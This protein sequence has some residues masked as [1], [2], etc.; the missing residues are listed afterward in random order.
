MNKFMLL[1][2]SVQTASARINTPK[3]SFHGQTHK[4]FL[5]LSFDS[6]FILGLDGRFQQVNSVAQETLGFTIEEFLEKS[7]Q[8]LIHP[9]D[10]PLMSRQWE[11]LTTTNQN[12]SFETRCCCQDGSYK[13]LLWN[14]TLDSEEELIYAIARDITQIKEAD[15]ARKHTEALFGL[16]V[17]SVKDYA[18]YMLDPQGRVMS[19]NQGAERT[20]GF[21][22]S[23][24][25]G[26]HVS[27]FH[28]KDEVNEGR[29]EEVLEIAATQG[30]YEYETW[31]LR[32]DGSKFWADVVITAL[33]DDAGNL[34][35]FATVTRDITERKQAQEALQSARDELEKR[36]EERTAQLQQKTNEL[37]VAM[38]E[39]QNTQAQLI[40][41][42]KICS[43]GQLV[44]GIAHEINNPISFI[45]GN[46]EHA[47]S[48]TNDLMQLCQLYSQYLPNPPA[49]IEEFIDTIEL[50]FILE[51]LPKLLSSMKT[52]AKRISQLILSLRNFS[53]HDEAEKK[54]VNL[55][56]GID[57]TLEM[58]Q[59]RLQGKGNQPNIEVVKEYSNLPLVEC[60]AGQLNQVFMN[61]LAN[62]IDVLEEK[63]CDRQIT[64]RTELS[65][66][67]SYVRI[68][69]A[70]NGKGIPQE[71]QNRIFDP[72][73]T[74]KPIGQ[75]VG[76][77]LP[78]SYQIIVEKHGG[79]ISFSSQP[80]QKTE[81]VIEVPIR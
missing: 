8:D 20:N 11:K 60:Y 55:H 10:C 4:Q 77:S 37:E 17:N 16:L 35:G 18:I 39:L 49:E 40:H 75:G 24:I 63:E 3:N 31:R 28:P 2:N 38:R 25:I 53:R 78:V 66:D 70:D 57:S 64:I 80:N 46:I 23:E 47:K 34:T 32:K 1:K 62:A 33:K 81:F 42:E 74:T 76:L 9:E 6:V 51:D 29:P 21:L 15:A 44:A 13:W 71:L 52:G 68:A 14:I 58:L 59:S 30:C 19:W 79:K 65:S 56:Q 43:L 48:Y 12:R 22:A 41:A 72:F 67:G 45:Y 36:V 26:Q 69:I 7:W 61:L 73:F 27:C 50:D 54:V 5:T